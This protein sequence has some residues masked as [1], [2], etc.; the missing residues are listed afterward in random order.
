MKKLLTLLVICI[1]T[2]TS[3]LPVYAADG[4]VTYRENAGKGI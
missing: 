3:V 1:I 2:L 4:K